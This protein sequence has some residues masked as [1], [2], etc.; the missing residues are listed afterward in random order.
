MILTKFFDT[1]ISIDNIRRKEEYSNVET[2]W[3][4]TF[5]LKNSFLVTC[6]HVCSWNMTEDLTGL[7]WN[8]SSDWLN[9][10]THTC[11]LFHVKYRWKR[12]RKRICF[13]FASNFPQ[14]TDWDKVEAKSKHSRFQTLS[15]THSTFLSTK[16]AV[17]RALNSNIGRMGQ[18]V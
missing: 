8:P 10:R 1:N 12:V 18:L 13:H 4:Y 11:E 5:S 9:C 14:P 3:F 7:P 17:K 16:S 2:L 6:F 15:L